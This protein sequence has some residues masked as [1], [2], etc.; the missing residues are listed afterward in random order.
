MWSK[1]SNKKYSTFFLIICISVLSVNFCF[2]SSIFSFKRNMIEN[3]GFFHLFLLPTLIAWFLFLLIEKKFTKNIVNEFKL[4]IIQLFLI[5]II[6][7]I[8]FMVFYILFMLYVLCFIGM[9]E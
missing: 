7:G 1:L 3:Y 6:V 9:P 2:F 8:L 5:I 4:T